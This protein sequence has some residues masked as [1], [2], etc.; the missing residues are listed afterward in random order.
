MFATPFMCFVS[1]LRLSLACDCVALFSLDVS[2]FTLSFLWAFVRLLW[3]GAYFC[4]DLPCVELAGVCPSG[5]GALHDRVHTGRLCLRAGWRT[6]T[7]RLPSHSRVGVCLLE[8][9]LVYEVDW[10]SRTSGTDGKVVWRVGVFGMNMMYFLC[11]L[12][13]QCSCRHLRMETAGAR[14]GR[15]SFA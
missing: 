1:D 6:L 3:S 9:I 4:F 11:C 5:F 13:T 10:V 8:H 2:T 7:G 12:Q 14:G 15:P